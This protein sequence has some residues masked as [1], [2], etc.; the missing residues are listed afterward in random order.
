MSAGGG[1]DPDLPPGLSEMFINSTDTLR[2]RTINQKIDSS[3]NDRPPLFEVNVQSRTRPY[4]WRNPSLQHV[5][6]TEDPSLL[7]GVSCACVCVTPCVV[8]CIEVFVIIASTFYLSDT[9]CRSH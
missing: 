9:S 1:D 5:T 2:E 8:N 4:L 3:W 6:E 7:K